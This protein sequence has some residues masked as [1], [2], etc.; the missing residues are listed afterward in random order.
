MIRV[1][2]PTLPPL[3]PL[4]DPRA[5]IAGAQPDLSGVALAQL[6]EG[7]QN[8]AMDRRDDDRRAFVLLVLVAAGVVVALASLAVNIKRSRR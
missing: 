6:L 5:E 8:A 7:Q 4:R 2:S 1:Q 3:A